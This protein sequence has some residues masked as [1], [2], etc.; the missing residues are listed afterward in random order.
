MHTMTTPSAPSAALP[1]G[2]YGP[3]NPYHPYE[4]DTDGDFLLRPPHPVERVPCRIDPVDL[5]R[6]DLHALL[7]A[8]GIAPSPGDLEAIEQ[9]SRLPGNVHAAL[10]RWLEQACEGPGL[11]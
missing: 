4:P 6:L 5:R 7:T 11:T 3:Y 10:R 9:I 8:A 2:G 1:G